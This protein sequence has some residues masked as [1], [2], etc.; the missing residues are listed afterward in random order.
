MLDVLLIEDNP[1]DA[2]LIALMLA[3]AGESRPPVRLALAD[4]L[5]TGLARLATPVDAVLLDLSLPDSQGLATFRALRAGAL[6]VPIVILSGLADEALAVEAV[7]AGAQDYLVKDRV[8]GDG[9]LRA[10]RYAIE[11]QRA[12]E[13]RRRL[14]A[15]AERLAAERAAILG[16]IADGVL[17]A[18][19]AG[20]ITFANATARRL[21]ALAGADLRPGQ[22]IGA[23]GPLTPDGEPYPAAELPLARALTHGETVLATAWGLRRADGATLAIEGSATPVRGEDGTPLGAVLTFRDVTTE[24]ARARQQEEFFANASHDLRTPLAAIMA[25]IGVVLANLPGDFPAP[26]RRMVTHVDHAATEMARLVDDLLELA[27]LEAGHARHAPVPGDLRAVARE[28]ARAIEPLVAARGQRLTVALPNTPVPALIDATRLGGALLNL[29]GNAQKYGRAGGTIRLTL[30][31][32]GREAILSVSDD[33]PG[34]PHDDQRRIFERFYRP[35]TVAAR[36][37]VGSGL[38]LPLVRATAERHGGRAWVESVPGDG[39]T[40]R[41]ALPLA[42]P[43]DD[44]RACTTIPEEGR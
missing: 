23:H 33:G 42:A 26:L 4:R 9:L 27:R 13:E 17:I 30:A 22:A 28:A 6:G 24:R 8:D 19:P 15:E 2:R 35:A 41:I 16:Q 20:R 39:A 18:D 40:F 1:G 25:S 34:I 10:L 31:V 3:E 14:L 43:D 36:G 21:Y 11:R 7:A 44:E 37:V 5:A 12:G 32:A 38:G 29:L